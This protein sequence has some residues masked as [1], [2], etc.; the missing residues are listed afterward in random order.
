MIFHGNWMSSG[1]GQVQVLE[2]HFLPSQHPREHLQ[3]LPVQFPAGAGGWIAGDLFKA[4]LCPAPGFAGI[5]FTCQGRGLGS[6]PHLPAA[7]L[8][9]ACLIEVATD[10]R[11]IGPVIGVEE[12]CVDEKESEP[13]VFS[14]VFFRY[15]WGSW[16]VIPAT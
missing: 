4:F 3:P 5:A 1:L 15:T 2:L 9:F 13:F 16:R 8:L 11:G 12:G 14:P 10:G 6:Q 7:A